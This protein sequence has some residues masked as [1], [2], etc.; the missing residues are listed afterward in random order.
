MY[1]EARQ[2]VKPLEDQYWSEKG[3][4]GLD[5]LFVRAFLLGA[6]ESSP[7]EDN[8]SHRDVL[9]RLDIKDRQSLVDCIRLVSYGYFGCGILADAIL[10]AVE[11][12][13]G[14]P[15]ERG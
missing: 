9:A 5:H 1:E 12:S 13:K 4:N 6:K 3:Q 10:K 7:L 14:L 8:E 11:D 2:I 15:T